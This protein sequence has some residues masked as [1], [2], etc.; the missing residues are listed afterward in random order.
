MELRYA[1]ANKLLVLLCFQIHQRFLLEIT[2]ISQGLHTCACVP[3]LQDEDLIDSE[4]VET[5]ISVLSL[6]QEKIQM[7]K[8]GKKLKPAVVFAQVRYLS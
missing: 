6:L 1:V 8:G 2:H 3:G 4:K 7:R 5:E